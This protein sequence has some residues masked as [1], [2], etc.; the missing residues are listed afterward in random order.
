M[1]L[2]EFEVLA[3][4]QHNHLCRSLQD[5]ISHARSSLYGLGNYE[6]YATPPSAPINFHSN[7]HL[8]PQ[9]GTNP[10]LGLGRALVRPEANMRLFR[11]G[12]TYGLGVFGGGGTSRT[13]RP[14]GPRSGRGQNCASSYRD[15]HKEFTLSPRV[16]NIL[17]VATKMLCKPS[18]SPH[19]QI[20]LDVQGNSRE[21]RMS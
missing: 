10:K 14:D 20:T 12:T 8:S 5:S 16:S 17:L 13:T 9:G 7:T 2:V 3:P 18:C 21:I 11:Q 6:H 4:V 19:C 15:L 1:Q